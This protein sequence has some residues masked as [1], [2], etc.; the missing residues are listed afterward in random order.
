ML[1]IDEVQAIPS[2]LGFRWAAVGP[3]RLMDLGGLATF[4]SMASYLYPE[5][6]R[7]QEPQP[8]PASKMA[9]R[10]T[11]VA[12]RQGFYAYPPGGAEAALAA[13]D[14]RLFERPEVA[15]L[16]SVMLLGEPTGRKSDA[17]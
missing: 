11:G 8:T 2:G 10:E 13:R 7:D 17:A 4:R 12:T 3:F 5:L 14:A 6:S 9:A 16:G 1:R 15:A